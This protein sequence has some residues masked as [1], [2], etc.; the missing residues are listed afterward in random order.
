MSDSEAEI[1]NVNSIQSNSKKKNILELPIRKRKKYFSSSIH[2]QQRSRAEINKKIK[3]INTY[4]RSFGKQNN[5]LLKLLIHYLRD[6]NLLPKIE[7]L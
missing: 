6:Q 7:F 4:L 2:H 1:S 5:I 3:A